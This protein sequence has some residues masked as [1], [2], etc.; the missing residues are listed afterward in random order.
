MSSLLGHGRQPL[1]LFGRA[2][3]VP[4]LARQ[5]QADDPSSSRAC[6]RLAPGT[7][8]GAVGLVMLEYEDVPP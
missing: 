7:F 3:Q 2:G 4:A 1:G 5:Q 8:C 6:L